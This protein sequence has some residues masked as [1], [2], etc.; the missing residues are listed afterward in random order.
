MPE[1]VVLLHG[2]GATRRAW[3]GV[4]AALEQERYRPL[5]LDL[6]GHGDAPED[7]G[8]VSFTSMRR[9]RARAQPRA[10]HALRVLDGRARRV[11]RGARRAR[12]RRA[13]GAR[14]EHR[15]DRGRA[16]SVPQRRRA[17]HALADELDR[18]SLRPV[19]RA[20]AHTAAVRRRSASGGC[21][22][23]R[24]PA[25]QPPRGA[26]RRA[27][28]DRHGRDGA[29]VEPAGGAD[30]AGD[31]D[32]RRAR[33]EVPRARASGWSRCCRTR[34]WWSWLVAT[35]CRWRTP[36]RWRARSR[37]TSDRLSP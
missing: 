8:P 36:R 1:S 3:D 22:R 23:A 21:A 29:V 16:S 11:A 18:G 19:H 6:P 5:A 7:A 12:A 2:F 20:L 34:G 37:P 26:R 33:S 24:G 30:D 9:A 15:R 32:R 31:R 35:C 4:I 25:P 13:A 17:D 14:G 10:L 27:A 28:R